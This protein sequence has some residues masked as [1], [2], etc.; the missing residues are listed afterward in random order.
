MFNHYLK[1]FA[2][3][4]CGELIVNEH[5]AN[6]AAIRKTLKVN[7]FVGEYLKPEERSRFFPVAVK[8]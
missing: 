7:R 4:Y 6:L 3:F 1:Q 8:S 2:S 5:S